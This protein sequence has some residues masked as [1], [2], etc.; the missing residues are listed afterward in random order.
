MSHHGLSFILFHHKLTFTKLKFTSELNKTW[1]SSKI[2]INLFE[3][4][5][6]TVLKHLRKQVKGGRIYFGSKFPSMIGLFYFF[7]PETRQSII[8]WWRGCGKAET[9]TQTE[10]REKETE[11][12]KKVRERERER[13]RER[14]Y[15]LVSV[16]SQ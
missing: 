1:Y 15:V 7:G 11:R 10:K 5:F 14:P 16:T 12:Q 4:L 3:R 13:K 2:S 8:S 9:C 6:V